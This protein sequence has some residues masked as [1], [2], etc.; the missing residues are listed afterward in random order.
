MRFPVG[1]QSPSRIPARLGPA[2]LALLLALPAFVTAEPILWPASR[3]GWAPQYRDARDTTPYLSFHK[4][5]QMKRL[6]ELGQTYGTR[7]VGNE[8]NYDA[9]FYDLDLNLDPVN[10]ILTGTVR[11]DVQVVSGPLITLDMDLSNG[12]VVRSVTCAGLPAAFTHGNNILTISLNRAYATGELITVV[13]H[14]DGDPSTDPAQAF[15]W[16]TDMGRPIVWTLSEPFGGRSWWPSK[17]WSDD[18]ADS[19]NMRVTA[20]TGMITASNGKLISATDDGVHS[21]YVWHER[22]PI[23]TYLVSLASSPYTVY[24][25]Y[26]HYSPSDSMEIKFFM[27]PEDADPYRAL[28]A[29][30]KDMIGVYANDFRQYPFINEKYGEAEF[31][32]GGGMEHQTCTSL[33]AFVEYILAHELSH[34]W[35]GDMITCKDFHH[36]WLNEGFATYC[37]ALWAEANG[38]TSAYFQDIDLNKYFGSGTIYVDDLSNFNRIFDGNLSY[39]KASW[40]LHMLRHIL[41][42]DTFFAAMRAYYDQYKYSVATTEN[43]RDVC[44]Q[45]S[46]KN[47][48]AYFQEWIY[49]E[50]Y[51]AYKYTYTVNP[52][53]GGYDVAVNLLQTQSWQIFNMPVDVTI[54]WNGGEETHVVADSL[55]N[56]TF[57]FHVANNPTGVLIDKDDWIL[58][59][60]DAPIYNPAFDRPILLVN[61]VDWSNYGSEITTAYEDKAFWGDYGIDFWDCFDAPAGGYPSTL[62]APLGH[63]SVPPDVIGHY[64]NVIWVGN[65]LGPDLG[66]WQNTPIMNY[67]QAGGNVVLLTRMGD[68]YLSTSQVQYLGITW[69]NTNANI[70]DCIANYG[71]LTNIG[72]L[73]TQSL[74]ALFNLSLSQIDSHVIYKAQQNYNPA[75]G[76]GVWRK[77]TGGGTYRPNGAQFVFLSGRPYRWTHADMRTNMMYVLGNFFGESLAGAEEPNGSVSALRLDPARPNPT[78]SETNLRFPLPRAGDVRLD[79]LDVTGR[80]VRRLAG[81]MMAAGEHSIGWDGRDGNGH[82]VPGGIY[83]IRLQ[84]AGHEVTR[85]VTVMR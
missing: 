14:Y 77:P 24:S 25:D 61:G 55:A 67:L 20:P 47:L 42:D 15:G 22:Y 26:Y 69:T 19:V 52:S 6:A 13:I 48:H 72:R 51:P 10:H 49:G 21:V 37:E 18:K 83:W 82:R 2:L 85:K 59:T 66:D 5:A 4:I 40:V 58:K 16:D 12:M 29:K 57:T 31:P 9:K 46:G 35:W 63:G 17:D 81:G 78:A 68:Q 11:A 73:G 33:G 34:Q 27:Y 3:Q 60:L 84:S 71:G 70:Y 54:R 38:G 44:E 41:G 64:R 28:N 74:C 80:E 53:G 75:R 7:E 79:L 45:V 56:Q 43:F 8:N 76:I 1:S 23:A 36:V 62:P 30:V 32:W 65:D 50:Y 39:N